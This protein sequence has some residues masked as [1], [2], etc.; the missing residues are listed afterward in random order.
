MRS[1]RWRMKKKISAVPCEPGVYK[2]LKESGAFKTAVGP[3]ATNVG[4][5][6]AGFR[7]GYSPHVERSRL[8]YVM[9]SAMCAFVTFGDASRSAMVRATLRMRS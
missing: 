2:I 6:A 1:N 5:F 7:L 4:E 3:W 8:R 9:A